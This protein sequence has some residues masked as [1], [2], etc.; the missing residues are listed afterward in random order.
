MN[1][2]N[3]LLRPLIPTPSGHRERGG[4]QHIPRPDDWRLGGA[5]PWVGREVSLS[6]E[7]LEERFRRRGPVRV[8]GGRPNA[9]TRTSAV[10]I[11]LYELDDDIHVILTRRSRNLRSHTWEVSFPGGRIDDTDASPWAAALREAEE[12]VGLD[13]MLPRSIGEIDRFV[14]FG[15]QSLVYP[16]VAVL[17]ERPTLTASPAEVEHILHVP[18]RE[19]LLEEV[20]REELWHIGGRERAL[21]FFELHG[22]TVWGATGAMLRQ[23]LTIATGTNESDELT[24]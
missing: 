18:F 16:L 20:W 22:D 1:C 2:C 11:A 13:P 21:T 3:H 10:L 15:S 7:E 9:A 14:T 17:D 6:L 12:E 8:A 23:L 24:Y 4:P 19:L 5:P